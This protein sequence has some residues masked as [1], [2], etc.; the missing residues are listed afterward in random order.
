MIKSLPF[1]N[2]E[3]IRKYLNGE[4]I[5]GCDLDDFK[6]YEYPKGGMLHLQV[7]KN[8]ETYQSYSCDNGVKPFFSHY[9]NIKNLQFDNKIY[10][11]NDDFNWDRIQRKITQ[12]TSNGTNTLLC[13]DGGCP[14]HL[15]LSRFSEIASINNLDFG[16]FPMLKDY[17]NGLNS[18]LHPMSFY[19]MHPD[20][21]VYRINRFIEN[22]IFPKWKNGKMENDI[23]WGNPFLI[24]YAKGHPPYCYTEY[25]H[26]LDFANED[27]SVMWACILSS[28]YNERNF[29]REFFSSYGTLFC[30][31]DNYRIGLHFGNIKIPGSFLDMLRKRI[32][33]LYENHQKEEHRK[34][35][36]AQEQEKKKEK[37]KNVIETLT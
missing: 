14:I 15:D 26:N 37:R 19:L 18:N 30:G 27:N 32:I 28:L 25:I 17:L 8:T 34:Y 35:L 31:A 22:K 29:Y 16:N 20:R 13:I 36:A 2:Q 1:L 6:S 7:C 11:T 24:E 5:Y 3:G 4:D 9:V 12:P 23:S 21:P 33:P 10:S